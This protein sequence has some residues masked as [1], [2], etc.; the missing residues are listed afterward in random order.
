MSASDEETELA[1][2]ATARS[3]DLDTAP[4]SYGPETWL[5]EA[6]GPVSVGRF[7]LLERIGEGGMGLVYTAYDPDLDRRLALKFIRGEGGKKARSRLA[8]EAK[9]M[10][11]LSH[12]NVVT[13]HEVGQLEG[14]VFIAM[15]FVEG[16]TLR[17]WIKTNGPGTVGR[18]DALLDMMEAAGAGLAAAHTAGLIH[19]DFKPANVLL[20]EDGRLRVADFGLARTAISLE[21]TSPG[22]RVQAV[23]GLEGVVSLTA[24]GGLVGTPAYMSPEQLL[25]EVGPG[26]DQYSY[27][28]T[29][30]EALN[31]ERPPRGDDVTFEDGPAWLHRL[32]K[33]GLA[34]E[35]AERFDGMD[36]LL[37][38]LRRGRRRKSRA[39][40]MMLGVGALAV[41]I[42]LIALAGSSKETEVPSC[43]GAEQAWADAWT[44]D[45]REG[46]AKAFV[47]TGSSYADASWAAVEQRLDA[48]GNEWKL[49][50]RDTCEATWVR[51]EQSEELMDRRMACLASSRD[52]FVATTELLGRVEPGWVERAPRVADA[53]PALSRCKERGVLLS[54]DPRDAASPEVEASIRAKINEAASLK[55]ALMHA[56]ARGVLD[57]ALNEAQESGDRVLRGEVQLSRSKLERSEDG[58]L[59]LEFCVEALNEAEATGAADLEVRAWSQAALVA[60]GLRRYDDA[61]FYID[62]GRAVYE[63]GQSSLYYEAEL[64]DRLGHLRDNQSRVEEA[65]EARSKALELFIEAVGED[66]PRVAESRSDLGQVVAAYGR[67]DEAERH[68][69]LS[70]EGMI[71]AYGP[72]HPYVVTP[73]HNLAVLLHQEGKYEDSIELLERGMAIVSP[74]RDSLK[75]WRR[76][77]FVMGFTRGQ[78]FGALGRFEEAT[79]VYDEVRAL[80]VE[81][82]GER[83]PSVINIDLARA[84][85]R[86]DAGSAAEAAAAYAALLPV[87]KEVLGEDQLLTRVIQ[88]NMGWAM[89]E[90][91][92]TKEGKRTVEAAADVLFDGMMDR[93][94]QNALDVWAAI[95]HTRFFE[96]DLEGAAEAYE[97]FISISE[98]H[99]ADV[100]ETPRV[101]FRFAQVLWA[102]G[103][104][105]AAMKRAEVALKIA[106]E[107]P[108]G[109]KFR[110]TEIE[111]WMKEREQ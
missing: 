48:Y 24:T 73:M 90:A 54:T 28:L 99:E 5:L 67:S 10:A 9:A 75:R 62:R 92:Q 53:M 33:K 45:R 109:W 4:A 101:H 88:H 16:K 89:A 27:C 14:H 70:L 69:R 61:E 35:E 78:D 102:Q 44:E 66:H 52:A 40:S 2:G 82:E 49:A 8:A 68:L 22:Q 74:R 80:A 59:S 57:D 23:E 37:A 106:K 47:D 38:E 95:G 98:A 13:V 51:R 107:R 108:P 58:E 29:F 12:P 46:L 111:A 91:G 86:F 6:K 76:A 103:D 55:A 41:G 105:E 34:D 42:G 25:G 30:A 77:Y 96:G 79:K 97:Q 11:K 43:D 32:L 7:T 83:G 72:E 87:A 94:G 81:D 20:G 71:R 31:G 15:E 85:V 100:M 84:N 17:D 64:W 1:V 60:T 39:G 110:V 104:K 65:M 3:D 93:D 18:V 56:Q 19:R 36:A 63:R 21:A 50:H 26:S